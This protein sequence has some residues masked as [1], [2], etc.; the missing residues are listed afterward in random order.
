MKLTELCQVI[1]DVSNITVTLLTSEKDFRNFCKTWQFH[2][3]Q[4]YLKT[5]TLKWLFHALDHDKLLCYTDC[6][7]IRFCFFWVDDLPVAIGPYCTEILTAQDY[8]RLEKLTRLNGVSETDL[9]IY[10]SRFPV[11]QESSILHLAHCILK[12]MLHE[13][14]TRQILRIDAHTFYNQNAS[15][16]DILYK[17]YSMLVQERYKTELEFMEN[18]RLGNRTAAL[19]NW[20]SLHNSVDFLK[21]RIGYTLEGARISAAVTRTTIRLAGMEA[22]LPAELGDWLTSQSAQNIRDAKNIESINQEHERLIQEYC[23]A[24]HEFKNHS[25]SNLVLSTLYHLEHSFQQDFLISDLAA[26]LDVSVNYLI[27]RFKE[28]TGHTPRQFLLKKRLKHAAWLLVSTT[29]PIQEI[30]LQS[31]ISDANYSS[32]L[33][34]RE[35]GES[36]GQYRK[37]HHL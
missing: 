37:K 28:E 31:G 1:Q 7:Q 17:P 12:H 29:L 26:E 36:P 8:K 16:T 14:T 33:F 35:Y 6:F 19:K 9:P 25:Y 24:I 5:D 30:C 23:N 20:K 15:D 4:D 2:D 3:K 34:L 11:T 32:R 10:R 13:S 27:K 21:K 18:I 22:G